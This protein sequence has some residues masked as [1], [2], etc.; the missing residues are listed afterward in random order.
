[1]QE[2]SRTVA[3]T[4]LN[5]NVLPRLMEGRSRVYIVGT[6]ESWR[7][8]LIENPWDKNEPTAMGADAEAVWSLLSRYPGWT[9]VG[10]LER[11]TADELAA[12]IR[13]ELQA[14][15]VFVAGMVLV[16]E[17]KAITHRHPDVRLLGPKDVALVDQAPPAMRVDFTSGAE[18]LSRGKTAA[19]IVRGRIVG[20]MSSV[21][22]GPMYADLGGY[23]LEP[24]RNQGI[25]SAAA[26]L[27]A[28]EVQRAGLTP[29]WGT[30][31]N[32]PRSQHVARKIGFEEGGRD[33]YVVVP[34]L[35]G[36]GGFVP[37]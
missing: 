22:W 31:E 14:E 23:V 26:Y 29:V 32:N 7:A 2:F 3:D 17:K 18:L 35:R 33:W 27:V 34:A 11:P 37:H 16:L 13:R 15:P 36:P 1:V 19:G 5:A 6:P 4:P 8:V 28:R 10:G 24:W 20:W 21:D 30:G 9:C 25:G 12:I